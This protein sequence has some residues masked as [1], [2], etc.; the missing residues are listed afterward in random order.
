MN[1]TITVEVLT[2]ESRPG[3]GENYDEMECLMV[4]DEGGHKFPLTRFRRS[5]EG[6]LVVSDYEKDIHHWWKGEQ[7]SNKKGYNDTFQLVEYLGDLPDNITDPFRVWPQPASDKTMDDRQKSILVQS[8]M[9]TAATLIDNIDL[10]VTSDLL[11]TKNWE[12]FKAL[13][14]KVKAF[15]EEM[16][17]K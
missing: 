16:E 4:V 11:P 7:Q 2:R 9:K 6:K 12:Y 3:N 17:G 15:R 1:K 13:Y 8:D 10:E 5:N 14:E